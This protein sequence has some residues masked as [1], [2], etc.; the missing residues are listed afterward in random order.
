MYNDLRVS[1]KLPLRRIM[2]NYS[3]KQRAILTEFLEK[4]TDEC[5]STAEIISGVAEHGISESAV[6]RNLA[7]LESEGK[8]RRVSK[9]G[10]RKTYYQYVDCCDCKGK[11]HLSC[12]KCGR[13]SHL[14]ART[15]NLL[16][17]N[18]ASDS[19]FLIDKKETIIYK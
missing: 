9:A 1:R 2:K 6:Y 4:H 13:T 7:S 16:T 12:I 8:L 5:L 19:D 15:G 11:I 18:L 3:T 17:E 14:T 10:D